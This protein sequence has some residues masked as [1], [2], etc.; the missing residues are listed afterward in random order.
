M[1]IS[2]GSGSLLSQGGASSLGWVERLRRFPWSLLLLLT[3]TSTVGF[4]ILYS[5][6]GGED[7]I[8]L[9]W[10]QIMQ[11]GIG[12]GIM[13]SV[14]LVAGEKIYRRFSYLFY[15]FSLFLL[16]MTM[17]MG[18]VGMGARRWLELGFLRLQTSELMKVALIL[19]LARYFHDREGAKGLG[20]WS[21]SVAFLMI[22]CPMAL[23]IKQPD[24]GTAVLL[25]AVGM[26]M[27][28][29]A[30]LSWKVLLVLILVLGA[31]MP[32]VWNGMH[33]YQKQRIITL[34]SPERDPL[35]S[36]Y[37]IIQSK[38]AV[39]S[40][41]LTGKG[42][43]AGSQSQ[44]NFLPERHTDFIFSVLAEEWGFLGGIGLLLLYLL[45]IMRSLLISEMANDRFGLLTVVGATMLFA[46]QVVVNVGMVLGLLPVV[47][48]PLPLISY[49]GSSMVTTMI[50]M[51]LLAH[52]SIH[53]KQHG[54]SV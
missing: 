26:T 42:F 51:G 34:F 43:M 48:V 33:T 41:G 50:A 36:G 2:L 21:M 40:G 13:G 52:V 10:R 49:G 23:I 17:I 47:G 7:N 31:S 19:A 29:V 46:I 30:G 3:F 5:A 18:S 6:V 14:A 28:V 4:G 22:L 32:L 9:F 20:W 44:L 38:I 15:A 25:G 16:V 27:I 1:K 24:L 8:W 12:I 53:S 37:H 45:I 54:R 11:F 35:G 39:G